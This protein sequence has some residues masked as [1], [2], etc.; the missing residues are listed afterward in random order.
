MAKYL[1]IGGRLDSVVG[2]GSLAESTAG[3]TFDSTYA[4][5]SLL[6]DTSAKIWTMTF[7]DDAGSPI[8]LASGETGYFHCELFQSASV[9]L[10][11]LIWW[12]EDS[13]G[14][15]W[16]AIRQSGTNIH[17]LYYNSGTGPSPTWTQ[18]GAS[19][20]LA[21]STRIPMDLKITIGSPHS[22]EW[23][24]SSNAV[25]TGTFTQA[26]LT[27]LRTMRG[28]SASSNATHYFSQLLATEGISTVGAKVKYSRPTANG[29]STAW[30]GVYTDVN[31]A[32]NSDA[33]LNSS[34]TPGDKETHAM[35]DVTVPAGLVIGA[36]EHC[37]R[38]KHDGA[39]PTNIKSVIRS[40]GTDY[41][42]ASLVGIGTSFAPLR[43]RLLTDPS[44]AAA[45]TQAGWNAAE[46]GYESAA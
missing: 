33:S 22:A 37:M 43:R 18:I 45:W 46:A 35:S 17:G 11:A 39:S 1:G 10:S 32:V 12:L 20:T 24:I 38:G 21:A 31:E 40:G 26:S 41:S 23:S 9:G 3:G 29:N 36:V 30:A 42:S 6:C 34:T 19:Q 8:N 2:A 25:V 27:S 44:T 4:D 13:S 16:L 28:A 14:Y 15:P 5:C 7:L